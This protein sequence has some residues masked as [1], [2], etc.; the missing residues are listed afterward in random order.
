MTILLPNSAHYNVY[1]NR[2]EDQ[3]AVVEYI[4]T[5]EASVMSASRGR[6]AQ[7]CPH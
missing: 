2:I 3:D 4:K 7:P 1:V 5:L 6:R